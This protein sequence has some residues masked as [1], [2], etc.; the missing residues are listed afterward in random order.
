MKKTETRFWYLLIFVV[1]ICSL[2]GT[3]YAYMYGRTQP[4]TNT[5]VPAEVNCVVYEVKDTV[6]KSSITVSNTSNIDAYLRVRLVSY[7]IDSNGDVVW[8]PSGPISVS[9]ADGWRKG[10]DGNT[11]YYTNQVEPGLS[12]SNLLNSE[13]T[14]SIDAEGNRQVIDVFAEAIQAN[15][16][17]AVESAW[18]VTMNA[19]GTISP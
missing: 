18:G 6:A 13:L 14:L 2:A 3:A 10:A 17:G 5:L 1:L 11:F 15:P 12:T 4:V 16:A 7:W 8:K 19:N 9:V